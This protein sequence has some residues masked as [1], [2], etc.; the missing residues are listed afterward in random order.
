MEGLAAAA[1]PGLAERFCPL[2]FTFAEIHRDGNVFLCCPQWSGFRP[3]GNI[4]HDGPQALWNSLEAQQIR[5]GILDGTFSHCDCGA[6]PDIMTG[7]LPLRRDAL[8][9]FGSIISQGL[10]QL[11]RLPDSVKRCQ[12]ARVVANHPLYSEFRAVLDQPELQSPIV[13]LGDAAPPPTQ[14]H[15]RRNGTV[16]KLYQVVKALGVRAANSFDAD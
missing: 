9:K 10:T 3:I 15:D 12:V 8:A 1:P 14:E 13:D 4:F 6:C 2:P 11:D 5:A 16:L 7:R